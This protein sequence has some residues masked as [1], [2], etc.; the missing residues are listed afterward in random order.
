[1][2]IFTLLAKTSMASG[3][4]RSFSSPWPKVKFVFLPQLEMSTQ[5]PAIGMFKYIQVFHLVI[6]YIM[7]WNNLDS[8]IR[9]CSTCTLTSFKSSYLRPYFTNK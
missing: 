9:N 5:V 3:M 1:M 7:L 2:L 4:Y 6:S 8:N